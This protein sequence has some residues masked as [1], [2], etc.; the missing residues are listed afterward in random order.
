MAMFWTSDS[1]YSLAA[2]ITAHVLDV[3]PPT[4]WELLDAQLDILDEKARKAACSGRANRK[5]A[6]SLKSV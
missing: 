3:R 4:K 2:D 6:R 5:F 1:K